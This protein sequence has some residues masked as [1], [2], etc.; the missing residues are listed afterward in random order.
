VGIAV[1]AT[2][3]AVAAVGYAY[4]HVT[5]A[6]DEVQQPG[7]RIDRRIQDVLGPT[8]MAAGA[9]AAVVQGVLGRDLDQLLLVGFVQSG[10]V[11]VGRAEFPRAWAAVRA[12]T[13]LARLSGRHGIAVRIRI[14]PCPD[15]AVR[16]VGWR[17]VCRFRLGLAV[18]AAVVFLRLLV[19]FV[20]R[21]LVVGILRVGRG[22][23]FVG[24]LVR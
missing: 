7:G 15:L 23:A 10:V 1:A 19:R 16:L 3:A 17:T 4:G 8:A 24:G 12:G 11:V 2:G 20:G 6:A 9:L 18:G 22:T 13:G 21:A 5:V 14:R